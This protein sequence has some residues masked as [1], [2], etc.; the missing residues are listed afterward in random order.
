MALVFMQT[1]STY[2]AKCSTIQS[3]YVSVLYLRKPEINFC[4]GS[5][6]NN[7]IVK[8]MV[9]SK[10]Y[11]QHC[12]VKLQFI[13]SSNI[14]IVCKL[15]IVQDAGVVQIENITSTTLKTVRLH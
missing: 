12:R 8:Y 2:T 11:D 5:L 10:N 9:T 1:S 15:I 14:E 6:T 4:K 13:H 3:R 7:V